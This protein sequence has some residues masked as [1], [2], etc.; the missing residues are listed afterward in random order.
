MPRARWERIATMTAVVVVLGCEAEE[1][2]TRPQPISVDSPFQYP[3]ELWDQR[4]EGETVVMV[5]V[6]DMGGVDSAYVHQTSGQE[7][8]DSA[9]VRGARQLRFSPGRRGDRRVDTW[10]RLP[11]R[12]RMPQD[13]AVMGE[14]S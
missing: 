8:F 6:T 13:S 4:I 1:P 9:A 11:V 3:I 7:A 2:V 14:S 5:H 12:F 10:A